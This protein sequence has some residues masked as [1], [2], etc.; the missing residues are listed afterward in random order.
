MQPRGPVGLSIPNQIYAN[1]PSFFTQ[2]KRIDQWINAL[3]RAHVG[4]TGRLVFNALHELNQ[5]ILAP[6]QRFKVIEALAEPT[7]YVVN[8]LRKHILGQ[9]FPLSPKKLKVC[10]LLKEMINEFATG[11][12]VFLETALTQPS[13]HI[14]VGQIATALYRAI[15]AE[16]LLLLN[17][18]QSYAPNPPG[19]WREI[20]ALYHYALANDI[21][22]RPISDTKLL[23]ESTSID[24]VYKQTLLMALVN[25]YQLPQ[26]D[27]QRIFESLPSWTPQCVLAPMSSFSSPPGLFAVNPDSDD[28]P[29]YYAYCSQTQ[30]RCLML[31]TRQLAQQLRDILAAGSLAQS[32]SPEPVRRLS[33]ETMKRMLL[34]WGLLSKRNFPRRGNSAQVHVTIGLSAV[35]KYLANVT[36]TAKRKN[37]RGAP[38]NQP[39]QP[40]AFSSQPLANADG[41]GLYPEMWDLSD[42]TKVSSVYDRQNTSAPVTYHFNTE[43]VSE[44]PQIFNVTNESAGGY[45]L[46]WQQNSSGFLMVGDL[47]LLHEL[48]AR[49]QQFNICVV[50]WLK[51][52]DEKMI[53]GVEILS[54]SAEP[55]IAR[56]IAQVAGPSE[57]IDSL[58]LP[59]VTT[60]RRPETLLT[61]SLYKTGDVLSLETASGARVIQLVQLQQASR[62]FRQFQF[63][64]V[65]HEPEIE[66]DEEPGFDNIWSS[67]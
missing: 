10:N 57:S 60:V 52:M 20:H 54:P 29:G 47:I 67:L 50:R 24:D 38:L 8:A 39:H 46:L 51:N 62:A 45:C 37:Q 34:S 64:D 56:P 9:A 14:D 3:P 30:D 58:L 41:Q 42:A 36:K 31:D 16:H 21:H 13:A 49:Y 43:S 11:Y 5:I 44:S 6:E 65:H 25:P 1:G 2:P 40:A 22:R 66:A 28:P 19:T 53:I 55:A 32:D 7:L 59:A 63:Q 35:A 33:Q 17:V 4:E 12:K 61:S 48:A 27:I 23:F 26:D 18:Y 15:Y